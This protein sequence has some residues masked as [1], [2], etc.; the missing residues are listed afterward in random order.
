MPRTIADNYKTQNTGQD[1]ISLGTNM[2]R[3]LFIKKA[4]LGSFLDGHVRAVEYFAG[5][6]QRIAYYNLKWKR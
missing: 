4:N 6:L 2:A 3:Y 1:N 5:V